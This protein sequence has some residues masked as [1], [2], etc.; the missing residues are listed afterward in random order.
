MTDTQTRTH[1]DQP[2]EIAMPHAGMYIGRNEVVAAAITAR[3]D[4]TWQVDY[5]A[6]LPLPTS[7]FDGQDIADV[8]RLHRTVA[9]CWRLADIPDD[10][11]LRLAVDGPAISLTRRPADDRAA[12]QLTEGLPSQVAAAVMRTEPGRMVM[13]APNGHTSQLRQ[14]FPPDRFNLSGIV[15]TGFA[16]AKAMPHSG[17]AEL[18]LSSDGERS[19]GVLSLDGRAD[20]VRTLD[21]GG[22]GAAVARFHEGEALPQDAI[23]TIARHLAA[24]ATSVSAVLRERP[25]RVWVGGAAANLVGLCAEVSQLL[26]VPAAA[27][28]PLSGRTGNSA[29]TPSQQAQLGPRA[30]SAVGAALLGL[31]G[32][33]ATLP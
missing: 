18:L 32:S 1:A 19:T 7:V 28:D 33:T 3:A 16:A 14:L 25:E 10:A 8:D 29:L 15:P 5:L 24:A 12:E 30:V 26:R 11:P 2:T 23:A 27:V 6:G 31:T 21:R 22:K 13:V 17:K 4:G 9:A 20:V